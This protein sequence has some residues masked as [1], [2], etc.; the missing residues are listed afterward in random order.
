MTR[1]FTSGLAAVGSGDA[2]RIYSSSK[3]IYNIIILV[4][5]LGLLTVYYGVIIGV[6]HG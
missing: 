3:P 4:G 1:C 6:M 5:R 2:V